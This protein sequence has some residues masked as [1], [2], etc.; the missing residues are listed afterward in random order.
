MT[1]HFWLFCGVWVGLGNALLLWYRRG[2]YIK[3]GLLSEAEIRGLAL[4]AALWILIPSVVLWVLQL[5]IGSSAGPHFTRWP[6]PQRSIA[7]ALQ[8][9]IWIALAYW[10]FARGGAEKLSAILEVGGR[11]P[12]FMRSSAAVKVGTLLAI[13]GGLVA[14]FFADA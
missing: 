14:V 7:I 12:L 8:V 5:S 11:V 1:D 6:G 13:V 4:G 10:V 2:K 9:F 3:S